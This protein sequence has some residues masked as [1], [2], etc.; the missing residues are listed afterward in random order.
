[1]SDWHRFAGPCKISAPVPYWLMKPRKPR[2][3][4]KWRR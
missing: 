2:L 3:L 1:M 4:A